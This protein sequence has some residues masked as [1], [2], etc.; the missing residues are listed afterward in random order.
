MSQAAEDQFCFSCK[1]PRSEASP[2]SGRRGRSNVFE[3]LVVWG[4]AGLL[5]PCPWQLSGGWSC[6][7]SSLLTPVVGAA[8]SVLCVEME[9]SCLGRVTDDR[10]PATA[11][12]GPLALIPESQSFCLR[13]ARGEGTGKPRTHG[14]GQ[15]DL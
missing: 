7:R 12:S 8:A 14:L 11:S 15:G 6:A 3:V 5:L 2:I 1:V 10:A 4:V 9:H 13:A